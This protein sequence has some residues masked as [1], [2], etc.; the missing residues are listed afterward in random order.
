MAPAMASHGTHGTPLTPITPAP[1]E[2]QESPP[3]EK[4]SVSDTVRV[5]AA[6]L[7]AL[8]RQAEEMLTAKQAALHRAAELAEIDAHLAGWEKE[9][10][11]IRPALRRLAKLQQV[12]DG[13][14]LNGADAGRMGKLLE[15]CEGSHDVLTSL[16]YR[17]H[18]LAKARANDRHEMERMVDGLVSDLKEAL[19]LPSATVLGLLPK[20]VR[21]LAR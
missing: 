19:L 6:K 10:K 4:I 7:D 5:S 11:K 20:M 3:A 16:K 14:S 15:Y 9:W 17:V 12:T 8:L 21:D 13:T 2:Q 18:A 1:D